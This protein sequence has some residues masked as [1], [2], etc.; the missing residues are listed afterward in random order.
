MPKIRYECEICQTLHDTLEAAN[1]CEA[2]GKPNQY[3]V[4]SDVEVCFAGLGKH[5]GAWHPGVI[6]DMRIEW[7]NPNHV[8]NYGVAVSEEVE[9]AV[10]RGELYYPEYNRRFTEGHLRLPQ[11]VSIPA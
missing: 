4:G 5:P 8:A 6:T 11:V 10:V 3:P 2:Q 9:Q 7:G 1:A